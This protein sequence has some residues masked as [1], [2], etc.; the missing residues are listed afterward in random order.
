MY[1]LSWNHSWLHLRGTVMVMALVVVMVMMVVK[2][3]EAKP[4]AALEVARSR[5]QRRCLAKVCKVWVCNHFSLE[6]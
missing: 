6:F 5:Q 1:V 3:R 2:S 4:K